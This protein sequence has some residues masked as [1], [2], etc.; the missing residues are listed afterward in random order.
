M[1]EST[2]TAQL[3]RK[4]RERYPRAFVYKINERI[5]GGIPDIFFTLDG[6][7][8]FFEAKRLPTR[9][10]QFVGKVTPLQQ[11]KHRELLLAGAEVWGL[12]FF[13]DERN[14][15]AVY[16]VEHGPS[17]PED[18]TPPRLRY[19]RGPWTGV[20]DFLHEKLK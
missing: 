19:V 2:R 1:N 5:S 16:F 3:L 12:A 17:R 8:L 11:R 20:M 18:T 9:D 4:V 6:V 13:D 14:T 15:N 7:T 10:V